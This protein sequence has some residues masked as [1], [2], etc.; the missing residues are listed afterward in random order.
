MENQLIVF[1]SLFAFFIASF[2]L[3]LYLKRKD[4]A[5]TL[6]GIGFVIVSLVSFFLEQFSFSSLIV[7]VL[8]TIWAIRLS[9]HIY[10]R[11]RN[12]KEDFR[13]EKW[14]TKKEI[15]F[16]VFI[17][18]PLILF[19]IAMPI[20]WI[21]MHPKNDIAVL[22]ILVWLFGFLMETISDY[23][24]MQFKKREDSQGK[25]CMA[26][27][28]S[29]VRH[30]NYLGEIIQ[31]WAIWGI[32]AFL[33]Y[34]LF[35]IFSPLLITFL[36]VFVSGIKPLEDK[37]KK[38]PDFQV[39][40]QKTPCLMPISLIN[41][42]LYSI[43]WYIIVRLGSAG[44]VFISSVIALIFYGGQILLFSKY[45][46]SSF[47]VCLPLSFLTLIL[48]VIQECFFINI[49]A[50]VYPHHSYFPPIW[51]LSLYPL[52]S[53]TINSSLSFLSK[54]VEKWYFL[55]F[56][57]AIGG[58]LSYV[59]GEKLSALSIPSIWSYLVLA[60]SWG[61]LLVF[62]LILNKKLLQIKINF[63]DKEKLAK[64]ITVFFDNSCPVCAKE[65][66]HLKKRK[67][68]GS[69][70]YA[71]PSSDDELKKITTAFSYRD[72]M[73]TIHALTQEGEILKGI[74]TLAE[75]YARTDLPILAIFLKAP[76]F[77]RFFQFLYW[78]WTKIR[79]FNYLRYTK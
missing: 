74:D 46:L 24:L 12:R 35:F 38:H 33:P 62:I 47:L 19:I 40:S 77:Y 9:L 37:M 76:G 71:T 29:Y 58:L 30:P 32:C 25:L 59:A 1:V 64:S 5:D 49:H 61:T 8:V 18:Q 34:G 72:S 70:H 51:L 6:W 22:P 45:D 7:S 10:L 2:F 48:G 23:Q 20:I 15:F 53:L 50:L 67:Q 16:K 26:G 63:T 55:F 78:I 56:V 42:L 44:Y 79:F 75:V 65:M 3:S 43:S 4:I 73:K 69:I 21:Q 54:M 36:I 17:L 28:W 68:T 11:N 39:Y 14:K 52:F 27:L 60:S 66:C 13:Y 31:W 41:G 57:G